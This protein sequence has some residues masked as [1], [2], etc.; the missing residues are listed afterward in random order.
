MFSPKRLKEKR[1][2]LGLSQSEIARQLEISR[3]SYS[4]W[5]RGKTKPNHKNLSLLATILK[6]DESYFESEYSIVQN[7]LLLT[8]ENKLAAEDYVEQLL[9]SQSIAEN[10]VSLYSYQV[11]SDIQLSA[12]PGE[13]LYDEFETETVYSE[14][15]Y[16]GFDIAT[17]ISGNSME[18]VYKD[19]EVALIRSTGFD[20]DGAVY[21]LNWNGSLYIKKLYREEDGFRMVSLNEDYTEKF[22]PYEDEP[23]IVGLVVGHFMPVIGG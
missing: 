3:M 17:W 12:G 4:A 23:R 15:E 19:G 2:E 6:V 22:I 10:V 5:E 8:D 16:T 11:L 9:T 13:G 18:P 14:D 7:Y 20:Y 21:A 1:T